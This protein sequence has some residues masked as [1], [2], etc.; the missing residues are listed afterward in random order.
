MYMHFATLIL[1]RLGYDD[2]HSVHWG[3]PVLTLPTHMPAT[4]DLMANSAQPVINVHSIMLR[5]VNMHVSLK[6]M[7]QREVMTSIATG[8]HAVFAVSLGCSLGQP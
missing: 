3:L 6:Q 4:Q 1:G 2:G 5:T 8:A 7:H